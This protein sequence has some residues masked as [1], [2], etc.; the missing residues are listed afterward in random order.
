MNANIRQFPDITW[1]VKVSGPGGDPKSGNMAGNLVGSW[2]FAE[3]RTS[4]HALAWTGTPVGVFSVEL[5]MDGVNVDQTLTAADF[6]PALA[7]PA[8][9]ASRF[10]FEVVAVAPYRRIKYTRTSGTGT[11]T[12]KSHDKR[13]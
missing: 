7:A 9:S 3:E 10:L 4:S 1:D 2:M 11:L 5:S 13:A 8:G 12:G 6:S